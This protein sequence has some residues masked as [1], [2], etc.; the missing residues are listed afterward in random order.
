MI[1]MPLPAAGRIAAVAL[2]VAGCTSYQVTRAPAPGTPF[3]KRDG[4]VFVLSRPEF[5]LK[6]VDGSDPAKYQPVVTYVPDPDQ[7][8]LVRMKTSPLA[9]PT[10]DLAF[11]DQGGL[12]SSTADSQQQVG[13][14]IT[15][16]AGFTTK[17]MAGSAMLAAMGLK[18]DGKLSIVDCLVVKGDGA[19][20]SCALAREAHIPGDPTT[21]ALPCP[22]V[23]T[24]FGVHERLKM[25]YRDDK[26]T[27]DPLGSLVAFD[28][29]EEACLTG[30]GQAL[31]SAKDSL[32]QAELTAMNDK[33]TQTTAGAK[34]LEL[35][36]AAVKAGDIKAARKLVFAVE[37][38]APTPDPTGGAPPPDPQ[39]LTDLLGAPPTA[40]DAT[41]IATALKA[42]ALTPDSIA[43]VETI[44]RAQRV[45]KALSDAAILDP[46][47]W[48]SRTVANLQA[49]LLLE[50]RA[51]LK[52]TPAAD[53]EN[54]PKVLPYRQRLAAAVNMAPEFERLV[55]LR[56]AI[57]AVPGFDATTRQSQMAEYAAY[58]KEAT[59]I[60]TELDSRLQA[61]QA[62][63]AAVKA[64]DNL[65]VTSPWVSLACV[66][67][68][69]KKSW[70]YTYGADAPAFVV[71]LRRADGSS[72]DPPAAAVRGCQ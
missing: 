25:F 33:F 46:G 36:D 37:L 65:P 52:Q 67:T 27:A 13:P 17:V 22:P 47:A 43:P 23:A 11:N 6:K 42:A 39:P 35:A 64:A 31:S 63:A 70:L 30:A 50:E 1:Q 2:L 68:S 8:Y 66:K 54:D 58:E 18:A 32:V 53:A 59:A 29:K 21:D 19:E 10:F 69:A 3:D 9:D 45:A 44:A 60:Q 48:R 14:V 38:F 5:S 55:A 20:A 49:K 61:A 72:I 62:K 71:V 7:R 16:V 26:D 4:V 24:P 12:S 34:A 51:V 28:A 15:A 57:A 41:A 40:G 56:R